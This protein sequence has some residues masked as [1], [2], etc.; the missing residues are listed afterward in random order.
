MLELAEKF[1]LPAA[2]EPMLDI[3][4]IM[5]AARAVVMLAKPAGPRFIKLARL[6]LAASRAAG[7]IFVIRP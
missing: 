5:L 1:M 2:A 7:D 3:L 6:G 4:P